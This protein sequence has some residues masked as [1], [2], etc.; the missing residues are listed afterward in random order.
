MVGV[1]NQNKEFQAVCVGKK[2]LDWK[3]SQATPHFNRV[4]VV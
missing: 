1:T 4:G 2:I 3:I